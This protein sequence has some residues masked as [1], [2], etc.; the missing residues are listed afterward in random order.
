MDTSELL[1][2]YEMGDL[3]FSEIIQLF[4]ELIKTGR[5]N[6]LNGT[7]YKEALH[8]IDCEL[9]TQLGSVNHQ[10]LRQYIPLV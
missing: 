5:I 8:Y 6:H 3:V 10:N 4:A 9:I 1:I 2:K 7:Y